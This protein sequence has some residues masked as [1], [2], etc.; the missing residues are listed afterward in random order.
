MREIPAL[1]LRKAQAE[2]E[3][4]GGLPIEPGRNEGQLLDQ[5]GNH[6]DVVVN[7]LVQIGYKLVRHPLCRQQRQ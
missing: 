5:L 7:E 3:K 6:V 1:D 2:R 4:E